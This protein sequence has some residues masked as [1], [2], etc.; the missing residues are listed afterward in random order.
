[1]CNFLNTVHDLFVQEEEHT[2][3]I[4]QDDIY[5][6]EINLCRPMLTNVGQCL[7]MFTNVDQCLPHVSRC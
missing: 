2:L 6:K 1:M 5:L 3:D 4:E 7:P